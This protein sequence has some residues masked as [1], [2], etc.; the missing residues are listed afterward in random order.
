MSFADF[1]NYK[2]LII[3]FAMSAHTDTMVKWPEAGV[4]AAEPSPEMGH[5]CF[6]NKMTGMAFEDNFS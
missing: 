6:L 3:D 2:Q 5:C 4:A 1:E